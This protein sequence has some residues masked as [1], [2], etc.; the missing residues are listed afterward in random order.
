M[1]ATCDFT[2]PGNLHVCPACAAAPRTALSSRRKGLLIGSYALGVVSTVGMALVL[3]GAFAELS[4]SKGG[5]EAIGTI[6]SAIVLVPGVVGMTLGFSAIDRRLANPLSIWI[7]TIW[8]VVIVA[9][10]LLL[11]II[12][13]LMK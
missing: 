11:G 9:A 10:F 13:I 5:Q 7:A 1:C 3:G 2:L 12:G 4:R 6:F 8:N